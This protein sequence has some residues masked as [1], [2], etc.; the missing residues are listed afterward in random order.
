MNKTT[1][2][3][4]MITVATPPASIN[5]NIFPLGIILAA[6]RPYYAGQPLY[7][8]WLL[9]FLCVGLARSP[10]Q[11]Y[12]VTVPEVSYVQGLVNTED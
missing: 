1:S 5:G 2:I 11:L 10:I 7:S 8:P 6:F 12:Q 9:D 4:P 3:K